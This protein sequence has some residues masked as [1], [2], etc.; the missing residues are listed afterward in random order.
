VRHEFA[1][2]LAVEPQGDRWRAVARCGDSKATATCDTRRAAIVHAL[3]DAAIIVE[4]ICNTTKD[5]GAT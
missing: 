4:I 2:T 3:A 1:I 5:G